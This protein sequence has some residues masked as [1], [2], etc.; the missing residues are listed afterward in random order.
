M[1]DLARYEKQI[2]FKPIGRSGQIKLSQSKIGILGAGA[3][4]TNLANILCRAG[5]GRIIL[6][7]QDRVELSNLQRQMLFTEKD[8]GHSK[9]IR[10]A[11]RLTKINSDVAVEAFFE[12]A[13]RENFVDLFKD[14]DLIFDASDNF[15]TRFLIN[16]M[17]LKIGMPWIFSGVTASSGQSMLIAP[18]KTA[19]LGCFL[20]DEEPGHDF[21]TVHNSGI[22]ASIVTII[23]SISAAA[24]IKY[25][26]EKT[27]DS[28]L[29]YFDAWQQEFCKTK[30]EPSNACRFCRAEKLRRK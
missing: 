3:L 23:A 11:R 28:N 7:D 18:G 13:T 25:L 26:V 8:V 20:P 10:A 6:V 4:G 29:V 30:I 12:K 15:P 19:C 5:V 21:P 16:D 2:L 22:I 14:L 1:V 24:G 17:S 9:A 27:A